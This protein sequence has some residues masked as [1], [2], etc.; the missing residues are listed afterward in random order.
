MKSKKLLIVLILISVMFNFAFVGTFVFLH[1]MKISPQH[2]P[3]PFL[4]KIPMHYRGEFHQNRKMIQPLRKDFIDSKRD[5][6]QS[7]WEIDFDK[8]LSQTKLTETIE[9]QVLMEEKL[10]KSLIDLRENMSDEEAKKMLHRKNK[11]SR[12]RKKW[13]K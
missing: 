11:I 3:P 10:G 4:G 7:L 13:R 9:K 1:I 5:F 2:I 6:M 12:F 8:E